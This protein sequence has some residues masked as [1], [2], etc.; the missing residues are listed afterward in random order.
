MINLEQ[1]MKTYRTSV[2]WQQL[3]QQRSMFSGTNVE[4]C[5]HHNVA[6]TTYYKQRALQTKNQQKPTLPK[7]SLSATSSRFIQVK[8]TT[9]DV[10]EQTHQHPLQFDTRTGQ[11]MLPANLATTVIVAIIKGLTV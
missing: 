7:P 5:Q 11:L 4:F 6:I 9:I 8:Q 10:C 2:Q 3:L 1:V